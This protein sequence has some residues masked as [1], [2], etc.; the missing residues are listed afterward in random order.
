M[1]KVLINS[2]NKINKFYDEVINDN[3][4]FILILHPSAR[5][6]YPNA[7]NF[8]YNKLNT[9]LFSLINPKN[10]KNKYNK[11]SFGD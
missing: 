8:D 3:K 4:D 5:N 7:T 11:R 2:A 1:N 6:L 10:K 9:K